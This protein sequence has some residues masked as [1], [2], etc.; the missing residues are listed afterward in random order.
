MKRPGQIFC[1]T[2]LAV[3][4]TLAAGC[5][6]FRSKEARI[7]QARAA[8]AAG[9]YRAASIELKGV[10]DSDSDNAEARL[11][12]AEASL[13]MGDAEA[14]DMQIRRALAAGLPAERSAALQGRVML[15][16]GQAAEL[17]QKLN[18]R[19]LPVQEPE[20]S[21]L[22][23]DALVTVGET[24]S[25]EDLY[26]SVLDGNPEHVR[27]TVGLALAAAVQGREQEA[28]D[29]L[30]NFLDAHPEAAEAW[31]LRG[32][33]LSRSSR[34]SEAQSAFEQASSELG[35]G[36]GLPQQLSALTGLAD[37]QLA[38]GAND[39]ARATLQRMRGLAGGATQTRLIA[40]RLALIDQDYAAAVAQLQPV[41]RA[42]PNFAPA[43]FL[44]GAALLVQGNLEQAESHLSAL[45]QMTPENVEA[46]KLLAK[47]RLRLQRYDSAM[48]V[49][50]PAM[51]G[52]VF[53]PELS[54]LLSEAKLQTGAQREAIEILEQAALRDPGNV[55]VKL[56]LAA[57][58]IVT[59]RSAQAVELLRALPEVT[60]D[61][62][63]ETLLVTALAAAKGPVEA[64]HEI[65]RLI[66]RY[67]QDANIL[68][69]GAEHALSQADYS[70]ARAY[71]ER[72]LAVEPSNPGL[73]G[74]LAET[75]MRAGSLDAAEATLK[76]L[77]EVPGSRTAARLGLVEVAR[78]RGNTV[79]TRKGLEQ[80]RAEDAGAVVPRLMLARLM[81]AA[82]E[83]APAAKVLSEVVAIEP[84]DPK[85]RLQVARLLGEFSRYDEAMRQV[86]E[87]VEMAPGASEGW[88]ELARMQLALD[89]SQSARESAVKAVVID[90]DSVEAVGLLALLDLR[91]K[92]ADSALD[93]ALGLAARRQMDPR[94]AV[95]EGDVRLALGQPREAAHAFQRAMTLSSDLQIA[96]KQSAAMRSARMA[97]PEAPLARWVADR[98]EDVRARAL[99][100]EAY[101]LTGRRELAIEHYERLAASPVAGF[102]V[103]NN[104]AWLYYERGDDRAEATARRAYDLA[105]DNPAVAD[106]YGWI[107]IETGKVMQGMEVLARALNLAPDNPDIRYHH[108]AAV[109][110][111]GG[112]ER[113]M[114][115]LDAVLESNPD[116]MSRAAAEQLRREVA[117][118]VAI[119]PD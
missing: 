11:A 97:N 102:A 18:D 25:A 115:L 29:L 74:T 9:D 55:G 32:E 12:L 89:Q 27:A 56:D 79:E 4:L 61:R 71:L 16:L 96:A 64:R 113:A 116:F 22:K 104:L 85:L 80:I 94:A 95:L 84:R 23:G 36:L 20:W 72:A 114:A 93:L 33:V 99:L 38:R 3:L 35:R 43:R 44:L 30:A 14:A 108:A 1:I 21:V 57:A 111:S 41:V 101:Q 117:A 34:Y 100:A 107:L 90:R 88:V 87:A 19:S 28:L 52:D 60:G 91:E 48:Q 42:A 37:A 118:D 82:T 8:M 66:A 49:L 62:R 106:T 65:E 67:P 2:M 77:I 40:A 68:A 31:L 15:A 24:A 110:R 47:T 26:R 58:Y 70:A 46:R 81:L 75:E 73:L 105:A 92:R 13:A 45:V 59:G 63:R 98:P 54:S 103:L 51:Q 86:R 78:L 109:A 50:T 10:L 53:D 5:D 119:V 7:Q 17:L 76:R 83:A 112:G 6:A 69:L 39:E